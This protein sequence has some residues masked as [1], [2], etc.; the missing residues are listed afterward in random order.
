MVLLPLDV[1]KRGAG[2]KDMHVRWIEYRRHLKGAFK[3][4]WNLE[5]SFENVI[6]VPG[7]LS[8]WDS[9]RAYSASLTD[10]E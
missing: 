4:D 1:E 7:V 2:P 10:R 9:K 3:A 6:N 5:M 8:I